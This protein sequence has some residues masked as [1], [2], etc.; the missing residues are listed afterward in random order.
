MSQWDLGE[1]TPDSRFYFP[2][3]NHT[4][5][6]YFPMGRHGGVPVDDGPA[7]DPPTL[8]EWM[9]DPL[10]PYNAGVPSF[11]PQGPPFPPQDIPF[12]PRTQSEPQ[13]TPILPFLPSDDGWLDEPLTPRTTA[14]PRRPRWLAAVA[15]VLASLLAVAGVMYALAGVGSSAKPAPTGHAAAGDTGAGRNGAGQS[16][17]VT[18]AGAMAI[19]A[20]YTSVNN[21]ANTQESDTLLGTYETQSSFALD[22]A[23][24]QEEK[25]ERSKP[26]PAVTPTQD[27]F[28]IPLEGAAYPHWFVAQVTNVALTART[29]IGTEYLV[30]LQAAAGAAWK[31]VI[32]P[33]VPEGGTAPRIALDAKGYA[34]TVQPSA[35]GYAVAPGQIAAVTAESLDGTGAVRNPGNL[36]DFLDEA[37]WQTKLPA[38]VTI[39]DRHTPYA[40]GFFGLRTAGGGA[41][42]FYTESAQLTIT[43]PHGQTVRLTI[44]GFY[45]GAQR[46]TQA[47]L[48]YLEQF[49]TYDPPRSGTAQSGT[50]QSG[51]ALPVIADYSGIT[52]RN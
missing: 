21:T 1:P 31:D 50:A 46:L 12:P 4:T 18:L 2:A 30:F 48:A 51:T 32:E 8:P 40:G 7:E 45:N 5:H 16:A 42:L 28:Y 10:S 19:L 24:Y 37:S 25:A 23:F 27:K 49:A 33:Y 14:R 6:I 52:A 29:V 47:G 34:T 43:P 22:A 3:G 38:T 20:N 15:F 13:G 11:Q 26:Y 35:G 44:P 36:A 9:T 39:T 17:P 41:L